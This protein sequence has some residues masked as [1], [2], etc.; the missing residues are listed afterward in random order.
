MCIRTHT[1]YPLSEGCPVSQ[2]TNTPYRSASYH[3]SYF[4]EEMLRCGG[5]FQEYGP[6]GVP[7]GHSW[8]GAERFVLDS[9]LDHQKVPEDARR[10]LLAMIG[11]TLFD[12]GE[13]LPNPFDPDQLML[14]K[15]E[16]ILF[17]WGRAGTGKSTILNMISAMY[18]DDAD[19]VGLLENQSDE[20]FGLDKI[21]HAFVVIA[22]DIDSK[23]NLSPT[24]LTG[25]TSG[26]S[27]SVSQSPTSAAM[28]VSCM[29]SR[30]MRWSLWG[31]RIQSRCA[32]FCIEMHSDLHMHM[33]QYARDT[34]GGAR[35]MTESPVHAGMCPM[36]A[37]FNCPFLPRRR[38]GRHPRQVRQGR[39]GAQL[40]GH[41]RHGRQRVLHDA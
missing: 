9:I 13:L 40:A 41:V 35:V 19:L 1:W 4:P 38:E 15:L 2:E 10:V 23:F 18:N 31:L 29:H 11:A 8:W 36:R 3:D 26:Q 32:Q 7:A 21:K 34:C 33:L 5:R 17:V 24:Q 30:H 16:V 20:S 22:Q 14:N 27:S 25:M 37:H 6:G 28:N 39:G 12:I